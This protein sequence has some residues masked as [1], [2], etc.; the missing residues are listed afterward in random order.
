[1]PATSKAIDSKPVV[2]VTGSGA[3]RVGQCIA[4]YF[5]VR[6]Y[7]VVIHT[8]NSVSEAEK[9]AASLNARGIKSLV[10]RGSVE[11]ED[12]AKSA[13]S[14]ILETFGRLDVLVNSAAILHWRSVDERTKAVFQLQFEVNTLGSFLCRDGA[15]LDTLNLATLRCSVSHGDGAVHRALQ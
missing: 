3:P 8:H 5:G 11:E 4:D 2:W 7:R 13:V 12:F 15:G 1:M 6:G 10:V 14:T 9:F